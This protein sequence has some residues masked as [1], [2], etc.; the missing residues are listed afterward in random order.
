MLVALYIIREEI[1]TLV[2]LHGGYTKEMWYERQQNLKTRKLEI[3]S[4]QIR[5]SSL[6][7]SSL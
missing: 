6:Q 2:E 3:V 5:I 1:F 7:I 4:S